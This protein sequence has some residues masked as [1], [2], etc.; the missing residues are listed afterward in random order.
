M[1]DFW[2]FAVAITVKVTVAVWLQLL[3]KVLCD[4]LAAA[5]NIAC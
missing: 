3:V 5:V 4:A 1:F 2:T